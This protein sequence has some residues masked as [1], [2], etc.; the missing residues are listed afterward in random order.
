MRF[1]TILSAPASEGPREIAVTLFCTAAK[2]GVSPKWG[3][4][5]ALLCRNHAGAVWETAVMKRRHQMSLIVRRA[6]I[7]R[8]AAGRK[9]AFPPQE[10]GHPRLR[11]VF[12]N[13]SFEYLKA[14]PG[15]E[16][17]SRPLE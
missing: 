10:A 17:R 14:K 2:S 5:I 6:Q 3:V 12:S 15:D 4:R 1:A 9:D 8:A 7:R 13:S 16:A 11:L